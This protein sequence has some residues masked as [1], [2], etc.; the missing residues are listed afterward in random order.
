[1][2]SLPIVLTLSLA[3]SLLLG[4]ASLRPATRT[5]NELAVLTD[6]QLLELADVLTRAGDSLR[7]QQYLLLAQKQ[8]APANDVLPRLLKLYIADGQYRLAIEHADAHLRRHPSDV[9]VRELLASL[10]AAVGYTD[11]AIHQYER[12]VEHE[13]KNAQAHY[14]LAALFRELGAAYV[15]VDQHYRAYLALAPRGE[16]A[17]EARAGLL[18]A[19]P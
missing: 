17:E 16:H 14:A 11:Q 2:R 15:R 7:A 12:V 3:S 9:R 19:V 18:E 8:G 13:P 5:D 4:C 10:Y 1:M 6:A